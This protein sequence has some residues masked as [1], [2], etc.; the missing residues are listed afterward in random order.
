MASGGGQAT[1][2]G[3]FLPAHESPLLPVFIMLT[4]SA[5]LS[6]HLLITYFHTVVTPAADWPPAFWVSSACL[7]C[8]IYNI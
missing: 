6:S 3:L 8:T 4:P 1:Y 2:I 7:H 5:S